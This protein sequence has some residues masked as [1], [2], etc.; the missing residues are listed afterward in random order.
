LQ[1]ARATPSEP[2]G[3]AR[4]T[5]RQPSNPRP[6][7]CSDLARRGIGRPTNTRKRGPGM[8]TPPRARVEPGTL[9]P[10]D[11]CAPIAKL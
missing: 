8:C 3:R 4:S 2:D 11:F 9:T 6:G 10:A 5:P 7:D 1:A